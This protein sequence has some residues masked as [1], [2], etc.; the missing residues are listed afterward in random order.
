M[1]EALVRHYDIYMT[2]GL[3]AFEFNRID[4]R[5]YAGRNPLTAM[6]VD[7]LT[8][9]GI[10]HVL[11]L[12]EPLE[13]QQPR[14]GHEALDAMESGGLVRRHLPVA[15]GGVPTPTDL[16]LATWFIREVLADPQAKLYIHCRA[17]IERTSAV[18]VAWWGR[19]HALGYDQALLQLQR[20]RPSL[21][22]YG[23]AVVRRW[24]A[25]R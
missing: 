6:D 25:G 1:N 9:L 22:R 3:P 10:T 17:G 19:Q 4:E 24:L 13:W 5:L 14:F 23:E 15:D 20:R 21:R 2:P 12:R 11:D 8:A 7:Q 16:D 18:L